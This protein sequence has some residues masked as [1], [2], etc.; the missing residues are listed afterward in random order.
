MGCDFV[1]IVWID[2]AIQNEIDDANTFNADFSR[3]V[4]EVTLENNVH[5]IIALS[6]L[7]LSITFLVGGLILFKNKRI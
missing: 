2:T 5:L 3:W 7:G 6:L 1:G 4:L